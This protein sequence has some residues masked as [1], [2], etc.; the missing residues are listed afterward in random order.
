MG[1]RYIDSLSG[2][3]FELLRDDP[4]VCIIGEDILDPYGG[5]FKVTRGLSAAFPDRILTT[6]ISE[7]GIVGIA[8]GMALRGL[9]PI[10][11]IM[12]GDFLTLSTDQIV[13][14]LAKFRAM[15]NGQATC[16]VVIRTPM[17]GGR[18]YGPT[19]SQSLEK[20]Y[21]GVPHLTK[22]APS[23]FHDA[24]SILKRA[25][26]LSEDPVLFI[27]HKLLYSR[28]LRL[29]SS[30]SLSVEYDSPKGYPTAIV[31]NYLE[32]NPDALVVSYGGMSRL[33]EKFL[34]E[35]VDEEINIIA[36]LPSDI[37]SVPLELLARLTRQVDH[38]VLAEEGTAN[39]GW[40]SEIAAYLHEI[41]YPRPVKIARVTARPTVLPC[42]RDLENA[43]L[44]SAEDLK[45]AVFRLLE[46]D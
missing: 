6:P 15:Y 42:A 11:E 32:G 9:R 34:E 29:E 4:S 8:G 17:G 39:F 27:E 35:M 30:G 25:V 24:G 37:G 2:A 16:P 5:A 45:R 44:P 10:V 14:H 40:T 38:V 43:V 36:C 20:M 7:A 41:C 28:E 13:N 23:H 31:R 18:G 19:H 3:L 12:F 21:L 26:M 22:L 1:Q 33:V 46:G